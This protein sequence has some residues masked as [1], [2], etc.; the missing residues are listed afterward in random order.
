MKTTPLHS[1]H[2][3]QGANMGEFGG[4]EMPLWYPSG[5]KAEH[6]A[7]IQAAGLFDT[8]H[9]AVLT[10]HG[11]DALTLLQRCFT[12]NLACCIGKNKTPLA[13]GR[14][15]YGLFLN[16][17]GEVIDDAIVYH[18]TA[19]DYMLVVNAAMGGQIAEHLNSYIRT[20]EEVRINNLEDKIGKIDVQGP[21][22]GNIMAA[23]VDNPEALFEKFIYFSFKGSFNE[24]NLPVEQQQLISDIPVMISRT[25]Y[26]G[27]FGFELFVKAEYTE[28]L[29]NLIIETGKEKGLIACGLAARDSL[30]SGAGLPLSHQDIGDWPFINNP[31]LFTM[32]RSEDQKTFSKEFVGRAALEITDQSFWTLPFAG[33]DLRKIQ[34]NDTS[35]VIDAEGNPIGTVLTCTSDMAIGRIDGKIISIAT[36]KEDGKP[37]DFKAKGL[38]CGFVKINSYL[39][40][41]EIV[42]LTDGKRKLKVEIR[43]DIRPDRTA[44]KP[45][46]TMVTEL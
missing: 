44:R 8:S 7:V 13:T 22:A 3:H 28:K 37:P 26:T 27:E 43:N 30:R 41:G 34:I 18:F 17:Q 1:W 45:V 20:G 25:G 31:W 24:N 16:E 10:I 42:F 29:W 4:Y 21:A 46:K 36:S 11:K 12:K 39:D 14:S 33:Y 38:C 15:V 6:L 32:P 9:M 40:D 35:A 2:V 19:T 5:A 23:L